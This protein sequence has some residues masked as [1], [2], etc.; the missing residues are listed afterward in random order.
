MNTAVFYCVPL[1]ISPDVFPDTSKKVSR[2]HNSR[3]SPS[4]TDLTCVWFD[5]MCLYLSK[6]FHFRWLVEKCEQVR[7]AIGLFDSIIH[8]FSR[9]RNWYHEE[10]LYVWALKFFLTKFEK[11]F[12]RLQGVASQKAVLFSPIIG[13]VGK[14]AETQTGYKDMFL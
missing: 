8:I 4:V 6:F 11:T 10:D 12:A 14:L 5:G 2:L 13:P 1:Q 7:E 9:Q 3:F